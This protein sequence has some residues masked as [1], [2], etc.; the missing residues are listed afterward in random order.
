MKKIIRLA[1]LAVV[2]M[3]VAAACNSKNTQE[4]AID[5]ID[6]MPV[7]DSIASPKLDTLAQD[8]V[9]PVAPK[10]VAKK[11]T[12]KKAETKQ[13]DKTV[14][15][16]AE[17]PGDRKNAVTSGLKATDE[18]NKDKTVNVKPRSTK[19]VNPEELGAIK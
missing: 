1:A 7:T 17:K 11:A 6:S 13:S 4:E 10:T 14:T 3:S 15:L 2:A 9:A 8:T 19:K 12:T 5:T 16:N 18:T